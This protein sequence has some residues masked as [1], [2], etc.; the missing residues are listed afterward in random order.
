MGGKGRKDKEGEEEQV[1]VFNWYILR[2]FR[3]DD[4]NN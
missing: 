3:N 1:N 2:N 4:M